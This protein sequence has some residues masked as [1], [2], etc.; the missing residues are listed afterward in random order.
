VG[1]I[2][3]EPVVTEWVC[4]LCGLTDMTREARVHSRMHPCARLGGLT[5]P[6]VNKRDRCEVT[7]HEREDYIGNEIVQVD[8]DGRP[9]MA[10]KT[11]KDDGEDIC[12]YAPTSYLET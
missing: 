4:P 12:V 3:L 5:A 6:M 9:V 1:G 7:V 10:V 11:V 8:A 2:L